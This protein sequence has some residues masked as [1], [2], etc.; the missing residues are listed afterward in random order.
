LIA[1]QSVRTLRQVA[2]LLMV[3]GRR[4]SAAY[5]DWLAESLIQALAPE[6]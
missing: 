1:S 6:P 5:G 3:R 2:D 4:T